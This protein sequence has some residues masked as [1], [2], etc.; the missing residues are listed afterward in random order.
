MGT[1]ANQESDTDYCVHTATTE[2]VREA[3]LEQ[4]GR[5]VIGVDVVKIDFFGVGYDNRFVLF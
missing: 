4:I 3:D 2:G 1:V 5:R